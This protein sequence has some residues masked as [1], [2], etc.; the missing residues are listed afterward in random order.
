M[1]TWP[2]TLPAPTISGYQGESGSNVQRTDMDA[3][4]ARQRSHYGDCP[5]DLSVNWRFSPAE[6]ATFRAFWKTTLNSG[7]D[8]FVIQLNIG[9]GLAN[10]QARFVSGKFQ[11]QMLPGMHWQINAKLDVSAI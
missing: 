5:D 1:S 10:Y 2:T 7:T 3:G 11:H 8:W 6:M 4:P 9:D